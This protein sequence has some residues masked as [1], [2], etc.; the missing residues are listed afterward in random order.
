MSIRKEE[1]NN[2]RFEGLEAK[3]ISNTYLSMKRVNQDRTKCVVKV[4]NGHLRKTKYGF[5]LIL[6]HTH[7]IFIKTWQ[8]DQ[9]YYGNEVLLT[10]DFFKV[11]EYGEWE[12]FS[13]CKESLDFETWVK[14]AEEQD[15]LK[16]S[17]GIQVNPVKW[18]A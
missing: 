5:I 8:V 15:S 4:G 2:Y 18:R 10:K 14:V 12:E 13:E 6:D 11:R 7:V 3:N 16:D 1:F 9:N 17:D